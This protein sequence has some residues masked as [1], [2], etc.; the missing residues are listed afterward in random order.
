[1]IKKL[2]VV[3]LCIFLFSLPVKC[4]EAPKIEEYVPPEVLDDLPR[5]VID[6]SEEFPV[7]NYKALLSALGEK[8]SSIILP[9]LNSFLSLV[10]VIII[11]ATFNTLS[12]SSKNESMANV[13]SYL[14]LCVIALILYNILSGIW[15]GFSSLLENIY[16]FMNLVSP[17]VSVLYALGGNVASAC[18]TEGMTSIILSVFTDVFYHAIKPVLQICFGFCIASAVT[19]SVNLKPISSFVRKTYTTLLVALITLLTTVLSF[20]SVLNSSADNLAAKAVKFVSATGIPI[21]GGALGDAV[22]G[23]G[24]GVKVIRSSFGV[25]CVLSLLLLVLPPLI[26]MWLHKCALSLANVI[27]SVF[28]LGKESDLISSCSEL[29]NFALAVSVCVSVMFIANLTIFSRCAV[30]LGG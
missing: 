10:G 5:E 13:F 23:L 4:Y 25:L 9:I 14:S 16:S 8:I 3:F 7:I 24:A 26:S 12:G 18:I 22:A 17:S 30:A 15:S 2:S 21:V 1:M 19:G 6:N 11:C 20:Q 27:C 28:S 29:I